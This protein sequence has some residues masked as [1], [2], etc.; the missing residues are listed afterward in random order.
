[1]TELNYDDSIEA[2]VLS[3]SSGIP[4][5]SLST[6]N[7]S[8]RI[9]TLSKPVNIPQRIVSTKLGWVN[10]NIASEEGLQLRNEIKM[11]V[12]HALNNRLNQFISY[13]H[14]KLET[15]NITDEQLGQYLDILIFGLQLIQWT[16]KLL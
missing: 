14:N 2:Y 5:F 9:F 13:L 1:L 11:K 6:I 16:C 3:L 7:N 10:E 15:T 12:V 8:D 4:V